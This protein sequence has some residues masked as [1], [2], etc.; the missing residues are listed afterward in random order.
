MSTLRQE[1]VR[2]P[3]HGLVAHRFESPKQIFRRFKCQRRTDVSLYEYT[4]V[5]QIGLR[6]LIQ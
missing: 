1:L 6:E 5:R 4:D 2:K 3:P